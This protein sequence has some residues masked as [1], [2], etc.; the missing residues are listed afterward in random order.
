[1]D[2]DIPGDEGKNTGAM[3]SELLWGFIFVFMGKED[4]NK[5][6]C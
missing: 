4:V 2:L 6:V 1:M 3:N 5:K